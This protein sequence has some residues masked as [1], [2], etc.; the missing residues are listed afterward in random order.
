M[1]TIEELRAEIDCADDRIV[2]ALKARFQL[3]REM[4]ELKR[5]LNLPPK[6]EAREREI[7]TRVVAKCSP[8]ERDTIYGVYEKLFAGSRGQIETIARGV[9]VKNGKALLCRAKNAQTSYLPGGHI[10]FGESGAEALAREMREE[11]GVEVAVGKLLGVVENS[12]LQHGEPHSEIN[13]VYE[14]SVESPVVAIE[15]WIEFLWQQVDELESA[16]LLPKEM[17]KF[18]HG[19]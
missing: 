17:E 2:E 8:D 7:F 16:N 10:E 12:F 5:A 18:V 15:P 6:D 4:R 14:M 11:A 19:V 13:L 1:K 3:V 9:C